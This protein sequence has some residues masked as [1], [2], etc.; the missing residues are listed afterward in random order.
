MLP[1]TRANIIGSSTTTSAFSFSSRATLTSLR[2]HSKPWQHTT[3]SWP[4]IYLSPLTRSRR[5]LY[6]VC[7]SA[8]RIHVPL[9]TRHLFQAHLCVQCNSGRLQGSIVLLHHHLLRPGRNHQGMFHR[10]TGWE[11]GGHLW[12]L[13]DGCDLTAHVSHQKYLPEDFPPLWW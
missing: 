7:H 8:L 3:L 1:R 5:W 13:Q 9:R 2:K 4:N 12:P 10:R 11:L 6:E